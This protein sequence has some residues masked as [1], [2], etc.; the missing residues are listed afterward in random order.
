MS[1]EITPVGLDFDPAIP[2]SKIQNRKSRRLEPT[3][4]SQRGGACRNRRLCFY[5]LDPIRSAAEPP[6]ETAEAAV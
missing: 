4:V 2:K 1:K 6:P 3:R 5:Q